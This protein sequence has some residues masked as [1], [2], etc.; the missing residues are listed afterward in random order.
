[1]RTLGQRIPIHRVYTRGCISIGG[2]CF[3]CL[4][5]PPATLHPF[6]T[7]STVT[8]SRRAKDYVYSAEVPPPPLVSSIFISCS[9]ILLFRSPFLFPVPSF[10]C[11]YIHM[12]THIR[13]N[14]NSHTCSSDDANS[15]SCAQR[16]PTMLV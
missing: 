16:W 14:G 4:Q 11:I 8:L 12:Y 6:L 3:S 15:K 7:W 1:M 5:A 2:R 13:I 9:N 10:S